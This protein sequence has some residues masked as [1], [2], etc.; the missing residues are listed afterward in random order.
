MTGFAL[1]MLA[2]WLIIRVTRNV[3]SHLTRANESRNP[4]YALTG[5]TGRDG[6]VCWRCNGTGWWYNWNA[7]YYLAS[8]SRYWGEW[9]PCPQCRQP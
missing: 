7:G 5:S 6:Y 2:W 1:S 4:G 3:W 8:E 9:Q